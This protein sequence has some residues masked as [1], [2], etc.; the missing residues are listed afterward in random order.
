MPAARRIYETPETIAMWQEIRSL[1]ESCTYTYPQL[2]E[3]FKVNKSVISSRASKEKWLTQGRIWAEIDR[4]KAL[5]KTAAAAADQIDD[6]T[7][8]PLGVLIPP[9]PKVAP[10]SSMEVMLATWNE[11]QAEHRNRIHKLGVRVLQAAEV[12]PPVIETVNDLA[13]V[14]KMMRQNMGLQN[15]SEGATV[16]VLFDTSSQTVCVEDEGAAVIDMPD[17][18]DPSTDDPFPPPSLPTPTPQAPPQVPAVASGLHLVPKFDTE[19]V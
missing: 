1:A 3:M 11:R 9:P 4:Q 17:D 6:N 19:W 12:A 5:E 16:N 15:T 10:P 7:P 13:T 14:D 18:T 2:A 8:D